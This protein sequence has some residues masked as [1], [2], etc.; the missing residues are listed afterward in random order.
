VAREEAAEANV[1]LDTT[2]SET[3]R[4]HAVELGR[5]Q[6]EATA[7]AAAARLEHLGELKSE[8]VAQLAAYKHTNIHN[9]AQ[10]QQEVD[11]EAEML[12]TARAEQNLALRA[13]S[14][15]ELERAGRLDGGPSVYPNGPHLPSIET[16]LDSSD[17]LDSLAGEIISEDD[18]CSILSKDED[19]NRWVIPR[20]PMLLWY[21]NS[22]CHFGVNL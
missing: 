8:Y 22:I 21:T 5:H 18:I 17:E 15:A 13:E 3:R 9:I 14:Y 7:A 4:T 10:L 20:S 2:L 11:L 12:A 19:H 16:E 6:A 1:V